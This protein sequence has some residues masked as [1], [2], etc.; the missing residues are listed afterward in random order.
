MMK[1]FFADIFRSCRKHEIFNLAA[2]ISFFAVLA[3]LPLSMIFMSVVG[4]V[5]GS[6]HIVTQLANVFTEVVPGAK[7]I[8]LSNIKNLVEIRSSLGIWGASFLFVMSIALFGSIENAFDKIFDSDKKRHFLLSRLLAILVICII[9]LFLFLPSSVTLLDRALVGYGFSIP[10]GRYFSGKLFF[11]VF[12]VASF[13]ATVIIITNQ[14]VYLRYALVGGIIYATGIAVAK[15]LFQSY[16]SVTF[17]KYNIIYG[18]LTALILTVI[19]IYYVA[20]IL[21]ISAEVVA[22]LNRRKRGDANG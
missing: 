1:N 13:M 18:S 11:V 7:D 14:R 21:L 17:T 9:L 4:H 8:F 19:W 15:F 12:A 6:G 10:L 2:S 20:N 5:M 22:Q 16:I 3:L